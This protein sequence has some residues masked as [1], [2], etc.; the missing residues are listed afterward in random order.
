MKG[1]AETRENPAERKRQRKAEAARQ[2]PG[3]FSEMNINNISSNNSSRDQRDH[4][5]CQD[6][7]Y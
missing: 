1:D 6:A 7:S 2:Q 5:H 3:G 4:L